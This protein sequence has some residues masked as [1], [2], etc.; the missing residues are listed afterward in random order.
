VNFCKN[1]VSTRSATSNEEEP[2]LY[3]RSEPDTGSE[4]TALKFD[5]ALGQV[6]L[7]VQAASFI[8]QGL[9][10]TST[11]FTA[12]GVFGA[13]GF[14]YQAA[15]PSI[16]LE[17]F[18]RREGGENRGSAGSLFGTLSILETLASQ[19]I[20][21]PLFGAIYILTVKAFPQ[22]IFLMS[23]A[24]FVLGSVLFGCIRVPSSPVGQGYPA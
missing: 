5:L 14:G 7:A 12:A 3:S 15:T 19:V 6:S 16:V 11:L 22:A 17:L 21:P 20:G 13:F 9:A 8:C 24:C 2:L 4:D 23:A 10:P 18:S 1:W